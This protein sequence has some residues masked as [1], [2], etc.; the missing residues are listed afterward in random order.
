MHRSTR[1]IEAQGIS[2]RKTKWLAE[3]VHM[4]IWLRSARQRLAADFD[5]PL[6]HLYGWSTGGIGHDCERA[7]LQEIDR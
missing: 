6:E 7:D 1:Y 5:R 2:E 3:A 4:V